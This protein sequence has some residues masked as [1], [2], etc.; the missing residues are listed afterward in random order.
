MADHPYHGTVPICVHITDTLRMCANPT[1]VWIELQPTRSALDRDQ[2]TYLRNLLT[3][4]LDDPSM[5][6]AGNGTVVE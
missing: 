5:A 1:T 3:N 2:A 4:W 6:D